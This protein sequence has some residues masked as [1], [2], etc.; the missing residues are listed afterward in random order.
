MWKEYT[1]PRNQKDSR[2][3]ALIDANQKIDPI[4]NIEIAL[5]VNVPGI[6]MQVPSLS[7]LWRSMWILTSRGK[8]RF[9]N[10]IHRHK[11]GIVNDSSSLRTK[12]ESL[13]NVSFESVKPAS[14]NRGY[15]SEDQDI[16]KSN[17][18]LSSELR[19]TAI[20]MT[21]ATSSKAAILMCM[22]ITQ[23]KRSQGRTEFGIRFLDARSAETI[24]L[25]LACPNVSRIWFDTMTNTN[26]KKIGQCM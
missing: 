18:K 20:F 17:D 1:A 11:P 15:G 4:S 7:D 5:I 6:E 8:E 23:R 24:P 21:F 26:V 14:G 16:A 10:E 9:V 2:P 25:K 19:K 3:F 13:E 12:E 22:H